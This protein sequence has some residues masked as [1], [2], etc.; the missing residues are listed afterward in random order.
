MKNKRPKTLKTEHGINIFPDMDD[1]GYRYL[2]WEIPRPLRDTPA[3]RIV[4]NSGLFK[5]SEVREL[6]KL[7]KWVES[8]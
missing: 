7:I 1:G 5:L 2:V 4:H 8:K 3:G 6:K